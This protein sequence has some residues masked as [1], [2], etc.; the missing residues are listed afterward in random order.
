MFQSMVTTPLHLVHTHSFLILF[1]SNDNTNTSTTVG[2]VSSSHSIIIEET[3]C[4]SI[5]PISPSIP[6][7]L[8]NNPLPP[9]LWIV[10]QED[11]DNAIVS[12]EMTY[13]SEEETVN[14]DTNNH[15]ASDPDDFDTLDLRATIGYCTTSNSIMEFEV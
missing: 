3:T 14:E 6:D 2:T 5:T 13:D 11:D 10:T 4:T 15:F 7:K 8:P 1:S 12:T 9:N